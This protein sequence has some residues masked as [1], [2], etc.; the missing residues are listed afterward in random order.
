M[1]VSSRKGGLNRGMSQIFTRPPAPKA[2]EAG[3]TQKWGRSNLMVEVELTNGKPVVDTHHCDINPAT[4]MQE[5]YVV[6]SAAERE[7]GFVRPVRRTYI[8]ETCGVATSMM[9]SIAETYA[10]DPTFYTGTFCAFCRNHF[11]LKQFVWE[12]TEEQVGS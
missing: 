4:G 2:I 9:Q 3:F 1:G 11:P 12:G 10:R 6:L 7:K 5:A 8:H